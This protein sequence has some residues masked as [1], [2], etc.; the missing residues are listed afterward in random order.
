MN[1]VTALIT[2]IS[3]WMGALALYAQDMDI[4]PGSVMR[5]TNCSIVGDRLNFSEILERARALE[6]D[7][8]APNMVYF[9]RPIYASPEYHQNYDFQIAQY[10]SSFNEMRER[11]SASG[12][13]AYGRLSI[14]CGPGYVVTNVIIN[15]DDLEDQSLMT[16]RRCTFMNGGDRRSAFNRLRQASDNIAADS[17]N[18]TI[19]QM[20]IPS[21]GGPMNQPFDF[22]FALV[23]TNGEELM[24]RMD[25]FREGY[26]PFRTNSG[27]AF[28]C[29]RSSLWS[30]NRVYQ[31]DQ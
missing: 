24:Q 16:T 25:L 18:T 19:A 1:K 23:G 4:P 20:W 29:D 10:Y 5:M 8:N 3:L 21:L 13:N 15:Q 17:G 22:V 2:F 7:E 30:T 12:N 14:S 6:F 28:S 31:A 11:R 27:G 26:R 9:R